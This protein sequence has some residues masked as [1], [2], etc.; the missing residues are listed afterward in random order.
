[1]TDLVDLLPPLTR[2]LGR[3]EAEPM[4]QGP[5][6]V[7]TSA[8]G[9]WHRVRSG[10]RFERWGHTAWSLWCGQHVSQGG[11][12]GDC[13]AA[14]EPFDGAPV[15]G[16]CE[17]RAI[18]A[19]QVQA[20]E[21]MA[22]LVFAPRRMVPPARCPGSRSDRLW[23]PAP[24]GV[25]VGLCLA[26]GALAAVRASGGAYN[27]RT[28]LVSHAPGPGLVPGCAFH[29]WDNLERLE[30]PDGPVARCCCGQDAIWPGVP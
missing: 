2:G 9:R 20:P 22:E 24:G 16:T 6:Y 14:A 27:P 18:G 8:M 7:R 23:D 13:L 26:C 11:R 5:R 19:G 1:M 4:R 3:T 30:T 15:C 21:G 17:G 28:G 12:G 10:V 29:A 25:N